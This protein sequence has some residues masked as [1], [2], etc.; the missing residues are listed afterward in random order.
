MSFRDEFP[1]EPGS[2]Y[3]GWLYEGIIALPKLFGPMT[4]TLFFSREDDHI[5][6]TNGQVAASYQFCIRNG[7]IDVCPPEFVP[8]AIGTFENGDKK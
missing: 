2:Y 6:I 4:H 1:I 8:F 3:K 7:K 5:E